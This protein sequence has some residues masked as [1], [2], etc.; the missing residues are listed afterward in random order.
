MVYFQRG[1][2]LL[3]AGGALDQPARLWFQ[4]NKAGYYHSILKRQ[5]EAGAI[6]PNFDEDELR[7]IERIQELRE[8]KRYG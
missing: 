8:P 2:H 6:E 4:S 7:I 1:D 3:T 5:S